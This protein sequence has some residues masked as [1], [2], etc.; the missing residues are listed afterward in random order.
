MAWAALAAI[1]ADEAIAPA[2]LASG[3]GIAA[4]V[5]FLATAGGPP[6]GGGDAAPSATGARG[7]AR[8]SARAG[9]CDAAHAGRQAVATSG[10]AAS[11]NKGDSAKDDTLAE[12]DGNTE[13]MAEAAV[14]SS[15]EERI[16][17]DATAE[18]DPLQL[19][20]TDEDGDKRFPR[21]MK[22]T[23][24]QQMKTKQVISRLSP[25]SKQALHDWIEMTEKE[26]WVLVV[27]NLMALL[28]LVGILVGFAAYL[29]AFHNIN[30]F[31]PDTWRGWYRQFA[32]EGARFQARQGSPPPGARLLDAHSGEL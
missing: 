1:V 11:C 17:A 5:G 10:D 25:E 23:M 3:V 26:P 19:G 14:S 20:R 27:L 32:A 12:N 18:D 31:D 30:V 9:A 29:I 13:S 16:E 24:E 22:L 21:A 7:G 15:M 8:A 2:L 6:K 28:L 4:A